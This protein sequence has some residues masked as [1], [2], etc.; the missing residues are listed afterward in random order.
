VGKSDEDIASAIRRV[1]ALGRGAA[2]VSGGM[3]MA[4]LSLPPADHL[5]SETSDRIIAFYKATEQLGC[6]LADPLA[7]LCLLTIKELPEL[8]ITPAG[9]YDAVRGE[10]V[11]LFE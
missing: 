4:E 10:A 7:A 5:S 9:L 8:R 1:A 3:T 6:Q 2:L 11:T